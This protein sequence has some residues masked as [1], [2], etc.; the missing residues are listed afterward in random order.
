M[1]GKNIDRHPTERR[2]FPRVSP[3]LSVHLQMGDGRRVVCSVLDA[4]VSG[5]KLAA[6]ETA[7]P[8]GA[9]VTLIMPGS[10][11]FGGRVV[12]RQ[13][14]TI[15]IEFTHRPGRVAEMISHLLPG[16]QAGS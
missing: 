4:S 1:T 16:L 7:V 12:R 5:V 14:A 15:A 10:V 11:H 9:A 6:G 3:D 8:I 2:R 13:G